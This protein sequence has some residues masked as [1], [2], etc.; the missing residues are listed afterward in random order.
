MRLKPR[1]SFQNSIPVLWWIAAIVSAITKAAPHRHNNYTI[2]RSSFYHFSRHQSLY[3][4]YPAEH[5]DVFLYGP[6]FSILFAPFAL[7]PSFIGMLL[8]LCFSVAGCLWAVSQLPMSEKKKAAILWIAF[9]DL[10]TALC[11]QQFNI[12][13]G[14]CILLN[15]AF[16]EKKKEWAATLFIVLGTLTKLYGIVGL[17]F[18]PFVKRKG[19]YLAWLFAWFGLIGFLPMLF[20]GGSYAIEQYMNWFA[21]LGTKNGENLF[22]LY[23]NV[24]L[25]GMVRKMT[26]I[27]GYSDLLLL[28]PGL[29]L[30]A[31]PFLRFS[32]YKAPLFRMSILASTLLFTVLFSTGSESSTYIVA[33]L[34]V[35]IWFIHR[36][37]GKPDRLDI[38]LLVGTLFLSSLSPTDLFPAALRKNVVLPYALKA[39]F[40]TLV[41]IRLSIELLCTHYLSTQADT[42]SSLAY[43][44]N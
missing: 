35:G 25:L 26:G 9:L 17:A 13:I 18:F 4:A 14:A 33:L 22:S 6:V 29:I 19:R 44:Q 24:S 32:Q 10:Y 36:P 15:F 40:P 21:S 8:W 42:S 31:L 39:L 11:M 7:L 2:F 27:A 28:V 1:L 20:G 12:L 41:W 43:D 37:K 38:T 5:H 16:V 30:F 23:Q 34:G 3:S